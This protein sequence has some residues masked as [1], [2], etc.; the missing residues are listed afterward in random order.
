[1]NSPKNS[2]PVGI[3][4]INHFYHSCSL[5]HFK[6]KPILHDY[7]E[8]Y[9]YLNWQLPLGKSHQQSVIPHPNTHLVFLAGKSHIQGIC[10]QKY[11]HTL[12]GRG[13]LIGVKFTPAGFYAFAQ[14]AGLNMKEI[15]NK[16]VEIDKVFDVDI[17]VS[18]RQL[19][20][21]TTPLEKIS[22][23]DNILFFNKLSSLNTDNN[24]CK[25]NTIVAEIKVNKS[26]MKVS[27]VA[28]TYAI[29]ERTLQRMFAK[30]IGVNIKWVINRYRI[31]DALTIIDQ[32]SNDASTRKLDWV[33]LA[34]Q[35]GYYDQAHFIHDFSE[36]IGQSPKN[37]QQSL[38]IKN[39]LNFDPR[40][41]ENK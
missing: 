23:I 7:I 29:S 14:Q 2:V 13:D 36:L 26:L 12:T 25:L 37:Y 19:Q 24:I 28:N 32:S 3:L 4:N 31:H 5:T 41:V 30:Y 38:M 10:Q 9:W 8:H 20:K 27:D 34:M 16:V 15:S 33:S 22:Y 1:M 11:T 6:P 39:T 35:L 18:E 40:R 21:L 17:K